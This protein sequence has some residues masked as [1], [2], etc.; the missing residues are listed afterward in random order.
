MTHQSRLLRPPQRERSAD[1]NR[2]RMFVAHQ[3]LVRAIAWQIHQKVR[4]RVSLEDLVAYGCI[5]LLQSIDAFDAVNGRKFV[6]YAW[7]RIRGAVLDGLNE[8]AWFNRADYER[9]AYQTAAPAQAPTS[10][11]LADSIPARDEDVQQAIL[12][13][14]LAEVL[15]TLLADLPPR[16]QALVRSTFLDGETLTATAKRLGISKAWASRLQSRALT[17]CRETLINAGIQP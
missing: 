8:M 15:R 3:G 9:G 17:A 11:P 4:S 6:T 5:G 7:H 2:E 13:I 16:E 12:R 14:E 1:A 10:L